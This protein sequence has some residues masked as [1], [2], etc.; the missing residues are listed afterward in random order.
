V[1]YRYIALIWLDKGVCTRHH[2]SL[3]LDEILQTYQSRIIMFSCSKL[4]RFLKKLWPQNRYQT[5][6][7]TPMCFGWRK[8]S[9]IF[10][11]LWRHPAV[12]T[13][14]CT[15]VWP[16]K[17]FRVHSRMASYDGVFSRQ[18]SDKIFGQNI[19]WVTLLV[20]YLFCAVAMRTQDLDN[21]VFTATFFITL[22]RSS[23]Q[24]LAT[25]LL[26]TALLQLCHNSL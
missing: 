7:D 22:Q 25:G 12:H 24:Q 20:L 1:C 23:S 14:L 3:Q 6:R 21:R 15:Y 16:M 10:Y 13:A 26:K 11:V 17:N 8:T 9:E 19:V 18:H 4:F 5:R 2:S